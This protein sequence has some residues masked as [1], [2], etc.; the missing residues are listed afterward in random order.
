MHSPGLSTVSPNFSTVSPRLSTAASRPDLSSSLRPIANAGGRS[1]AR[2]EVK[3]QKKPEPKYD[4]S[5]SE[6]N[7]P[8]A[9]E[10][11]WTATDRLC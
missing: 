9:E 7:V 5:G 11:V 6:E 3:K 10:E 2:R 1:R 8:P 4:S